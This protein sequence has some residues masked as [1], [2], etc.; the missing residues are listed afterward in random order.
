M[1]C[2]PCLLCVESYTP[3]N[4]FMLKHKQLVLQVQYSSSHLTF[5]VQ[6][7][8]EMELAACSVLQ[9]EKKLSHSEDPCVLPA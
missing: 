7:L 2:V 5:T 6:C 3:S 8:L 1:C 4:V 9:A